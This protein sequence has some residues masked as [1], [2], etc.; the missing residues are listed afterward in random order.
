[1]TG[2]LT[3]PLRMLATLVLVAGLVAG[4]F[5]REEVLR[6][7]RR[8]LRLPDPPSAVGRPDPGS[9]AS[10]TARIDSLVGGRADSVLVTPAE[11]ASLAAGLLGR[12]AGE[13]VDSLEVELDDRELALRARVATAPLPA[14]IRDVLGGA[15]AERETV[16]VTGALGLRRAGVGE[17]EVRRVRV[18]GFPVPR[19]LVGRLLGRYL[20]RIEGRMVLFDVPEA[21]TGI[22][23]TPRGVVLYGSGT[24]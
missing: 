9:L 15:L 3:F 13:T 16:E 18:R 20:P 2:C 21:V 10:G 19:D 4:W 23:V 5:Y 22:R 1:M 7:G 11:L 24:R 8:Q 17:L 14:S 12:A 6:F